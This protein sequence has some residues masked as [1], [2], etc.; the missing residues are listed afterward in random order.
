M[1]EM[2]PSPPILRVRRSVQSGNKTM[3]AAWAA[4]Y[5]SSSTYAYMFG[6]GSIDLTNMAAGDIVNVRIRKQVDPSGGV[7]NHDQKQ[8][9]GV[10]PDERKQFKI[11]SILD[12]Y[13]LSIEMQQT[14]GALRTFYCEFFD[15]RR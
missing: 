1:A 5:S 13:G 6:Q 7:I 3:A 2:Y 8:F 11:G 9:F 15:A 4:V 12:V 14:A 10:Q